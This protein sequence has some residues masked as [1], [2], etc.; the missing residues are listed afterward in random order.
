MGSGHRTGCEAKHLITCLEL[1]RGRLPAAS[2]ARIQQFMV[3]WAMLPH[4]D[5]RDGAESGCIEDEVPLRGPRDEDVM[6]VFVL[7]KDLGNG[8]DGLLL[9]EPLKDV[10]ERALLSKFRLKTRDVFLRSAVGLSDWNFSHGER[11]RVHA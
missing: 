2:E 3:R 5:R 7:R 1:R 10:P 8:A 4:G 6:C 9:T 11:P